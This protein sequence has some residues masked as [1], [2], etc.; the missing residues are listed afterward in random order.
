MRPLAIGYRDTTTTKHG[1]FG[2]GPGATAGDGLYYA[3][4]SDDHRAYVWEVP[5][6]E[7]LKA[8]REMDWSVSSFKASE[9]DVGA[10]D[11]ALAP[12]S[13]NQRS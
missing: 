10:H 5:S 7:K 2:G 12:R 4:G 1:S 6:V 11:T 9:R 13:A 8:Q 3:A